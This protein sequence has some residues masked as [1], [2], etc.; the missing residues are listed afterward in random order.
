MSGGS[1]VKI[2]RLNSLNRDPSQIRSKGISG[3]TMPN[4][5]SPCEK[6]QGNTCPFALA[7]TWK[8]GNRQY[9]TCRRAALDRA[10]EA[11]GA[12]REKGLGL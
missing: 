5:A 7:E 9:G 4:A 8:K 3:V 1:F 6:G 10:M 2:R 11:E 12:L